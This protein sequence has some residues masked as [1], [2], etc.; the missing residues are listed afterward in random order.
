MGWQLESLLLDSS[1]G[2]LR[3]WVAN[4]TILKNDV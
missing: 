4:A 2:A 3:S 1:A